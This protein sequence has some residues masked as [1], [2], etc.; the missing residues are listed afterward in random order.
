[1]EPQVNLRSRVFRHANSH[2]RLTKAEQAT[3]ELMKKGLT[4]DAI[5]VSL[6]LKHETIKNRIRL[7]QEKLDDEA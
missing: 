6:G 5:A 7:I 4:S 3:Y 1:M 2:V